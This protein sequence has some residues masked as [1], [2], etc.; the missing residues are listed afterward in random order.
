MTVCFSCSIIAHLLVDLFIK[1]SGAKEVENL[2]SCGCSA[3]RSRNE[4]WAVRLAH[5]IPGQPR[6]LGD[7]LP[8]ED[9][10]R[11]AVLRLEEIGPPFLR[12]IAGEC[13]N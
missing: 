9:Q 13:D 7:S 8:L 4:L 6:L 12:S 5:Q 1:G 3:I 11:A 2:G 10:E